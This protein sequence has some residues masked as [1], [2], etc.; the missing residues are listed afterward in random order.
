MDRN[1]I[2][3]DHECL[4]ILLQ[5]QNVVPCSVYTTFLLYM[6]YM[7]HA[8]IAAQNCFTL[9]VHTGVTKETLINE[10]IHTIIIYKMTDCVRCG[11]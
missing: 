11:S 4:C 7:I 5:W 10:K 8:Y 6:I 3:K 9:Q 2:E 1:F